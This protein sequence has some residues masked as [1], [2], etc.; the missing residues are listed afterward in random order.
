[1]SVERVGGH[2]QNAALACVERQVTRIHR[3]RVAPRSAGVELVMVGHQ[4]DDGVIVAT[5]GAEAQ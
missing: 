1:M 2:E 3:S 4:V 5:F